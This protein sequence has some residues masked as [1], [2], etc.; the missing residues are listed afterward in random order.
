[1]P[2]PCT[3]TSSIQNDIYAPA[4]DV[5]SPVENRLVVVTDV[6]CNSVGVNPILFDVCVRTEW[7]ATWESKWMAKCVSDILSAKLYST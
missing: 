6:C 5:S 4:P 7:F 3:Y 2:S 1:M